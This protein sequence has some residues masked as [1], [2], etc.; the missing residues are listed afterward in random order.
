MT[1]K[2][3]Y[4]NNQWHTVIFSRQQTQGRLLINGEDESVGESAGD[5]RAMSI[6]G[7]FYVGG[8]NPNILTDSNNN[9]GLEKGDFFRGCIRNIQSGGRDLGEPTQVVGV[10][11]CSEQIESGMFFGKG[12]G[13]V[14]LRDRFR[15]GVEMTISMDIKPRTMNGLL[16]SVHGKKALLLL[17]LI[18]GTIHFT[19]NNGEGNIIAIFKPEP[20]QNFCDGEWHSVKAVKSK[21]VITLIV[22]GVNS[23]PAIGSTTSLSTDTTRPLFLGGHPYLSKARG[24][25]IRRPF[26]G[27]IRNVRVKDQ[28]Q[29]INTAMT[30]GNVQT[31]VCPLN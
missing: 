3:E 12:G 21:Y 26:L 23:E 27:C 13:H 10:Q 14:K 11:P 30:V 28:V 9:L 20:N 1:S 24:L 17:Q 4:N 25:S 31:G 7:P 22:D 19:V 29:E 6:Q 18:N 8:V 5:T 2:F 16:L 15:V